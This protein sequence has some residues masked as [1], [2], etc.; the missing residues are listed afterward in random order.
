MEPSDEAEPIL[1]TVDPEAPLSADFLAAIID[2]VA[3]PIFIKDRAFCY[4]L[5]NR[6]TAAM[7][8]R[9]PEAMLGKTD[10]DFFSHDEA[11]F[12]RQ[13][14]VEMFSTGSRVTIDEEPITDTE[15]RRRLLATTKVPLRDASG[16]V[17]HL[18]GIV[19]DITRLKAAEE[20]LR[21]ANEQLE[22]RVRERTAALQA[23]Q[24]ELVRKERLAV[25]GQ[26]AGG[27]AHQIRNPL[28]A[29]ANAAYVLQ[30]TVTAPSEDSAYAIS[31]ILEEAWQ[32]NRIISDLIDYARVRPPERRDVP[33]REIVERALTAQPV[34]GHVR[35][36][37]ELPDEPLASVDPDQV[38]GALENLICN[39]V[40]AM[41]EGGDLR[42]SAAP[43]GGMIRLGIADTGAGISPEMQEK[44][45]EPLV[46][47]KPL[48]L[49][50]GL[51]TTR[52][53]IENQG[54]KITCE[55]MPGRGTRFDVTLPIAS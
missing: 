45:F 6:A 9:T 44:L 50:L 15:G 21:L 36:T 35:V 28:G 31:I 54:G 8:G 40:E 18:V 12:F 23:A 51:T 5:V 52:A 25:L 14:D 10:Y 24:S 1:K 49:G 17:T 34:P 47:T 43:E 30:R 16:D 53:L 39:A 3:D 46:T 38:R 26:L 37:L 7:A 41:P 27:L 32:A 55:S 13:K 20:A 29:I 33:V 48:G 11:D 2:H 4:V 42:I 22:L 19:H